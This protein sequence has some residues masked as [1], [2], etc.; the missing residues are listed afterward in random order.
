MCEMCDRAGI[1]DPDRTYAPIRLTCK[2]A[3]LASAFC[4]IMIEM[5]AGFTDERGAR[6]EPFVEGETVVMPWAGHP[7]FVNRVTEIAT[8]IRVA[9]ATAVRSMTYGAMSQVLATDES[10]IVEFGET[11]A[12]AM[13]SFMATIGTKR[14]VDIDGLMSTLEA[15]LAA[16][17][18]DDKGAE[19]R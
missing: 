3:V 16:I 14:P 1:N 13:S 19:G 17:Q 11:M 18:D 8:L 7:R 12:S 9:E 15:D 2:S 10:N 6:L 4:T 5:G